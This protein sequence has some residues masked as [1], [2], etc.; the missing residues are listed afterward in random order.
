MS[1]GISYW[2]GYPALPDERIALLNQFGFDSVSLHWTN[3]YEYITG[4]KEL[5]AKKLSEKNIFI[6]SFHLSYDKAF[7]FWENS[8]NGH[9]YRKS[10]IDAIVKAKK[11]QV[12]VI[13]MHTDGKAFEYQKIKYLEYL[14]EI[15]EKNSIKLCLENLQKTD[16]IDKIINYFTTSKIQLCYDCGH[17]NIHKCSFEVKNNPNIQY[18]HLNDNYGVGDIHL[19]PG[20]GNVDWSQECQKLITLPNVM[21]GILEVHK[22]LKTREEAEKYLQKVYDST[23]YWKKK[24]KI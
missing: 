8:A 12:P 7:L 3:E 1:L 20:E 22:E 19:I 9:H 6:S 11:Y 4:K 16:H 10:I 21:N 2:F 18:V 23:K 17:A 14:Y 5:V 13:V 24:I 15:A